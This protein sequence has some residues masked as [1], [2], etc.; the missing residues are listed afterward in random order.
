MGSLLSFSDRWESW[1]TACLFSLFNI[2]CRVKTKLRVQPSYF[3]LQ[4]LCCFRRSTPASWSAISNPLV[5][6]LL[7]FLSST[8]PLLLFIPSLPAPPFP[9]SLHSPFRILCLLFPFL[10][11][12]FSLFFS[13]CL[14]FT[15]R[16]T[17]AAEGASN[18]SNCAPPPNFNGLDQ[19]GPWSE[20][21]ISKRSY[22]L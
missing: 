16:L 17:L 8:S 3:R 1:E 18:W 21:S 13:F 22:S 11:F 4:N 9:S 19:Q 20:R 14:K 2:T 5:P 6:C 12:L 10:S 7:L 15:A